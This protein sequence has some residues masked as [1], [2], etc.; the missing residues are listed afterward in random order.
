MKK[1]LAILLCGAML[2]AFAACGE[3]TQTPEK[4]SDA[5][6][7]TEAP[8]PE[9][10]EA[11]AVPAF[12]VTTATSGDFEIT[13]LGAE[14]VTTR[15]DAPGIRIYYQ[16]TNNATYN[17]RAVDDLSIDVLQ[18]DTA[19]EAEFAKEKVD[20]DAAKESYV[21]PGT[22]I[23]C[24]AI[25]GL[26]DDSSAVKLSIGSFKAG[27]MIEVEFDLANLPGAP[28]E[29]FE[30]AAVTEGL[31]AEGL[32]A[33]GTLDEKYQVKINGA[34]KV[35]KADGSECLLVHYTFTNN[36]DKE[37][38]FLSSVAAKV[39]QDGIALEQT[40]PVDATEQKFMNRTEK[41]A[42]GES[43]DVDLCFALNSASPVE[44]EVHD[45]HISMA[46]D[47]YFEERIG[48]VFNLG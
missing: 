48:L 5:P 12:E 3:K 19:L 18:N 37:N 46:T 11:P 20:E 17:V 8:A 2:L 42:V 24:T 47:E 25:R 30:I 31:Q 44:I 43:L 34:E 13:V 41:V 23:R 35:T 28:T 1:L 32:S 15:D 21:R 27:E 22:S 7:T 9:T 6:Q 36:S 45:T 26:V 33:E 4:E 40:V 10:Q 29:A 39:F 14:A 16:Y 38:S